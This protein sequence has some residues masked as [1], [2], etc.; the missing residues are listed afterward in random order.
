M[1]ELS[2]AGPEEGLTSE[3]QALVVSLQAKHGNKLKKIVAKL[4]GHTPK[5][6]DPTCF[7][8]MGTLIQL[9][10]EVDEGRQSWMQQ[11]NEAMWRLSRLK[12]RL[13]SVKGRKRTEAVEKSR[14]R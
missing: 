2:G 6:I 9:C 13:E 3:E 11:K 5:R 1:E 14:R 4:P 7:H 12:Q 10:K 8:Q